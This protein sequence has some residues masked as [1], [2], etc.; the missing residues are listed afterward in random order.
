VREELERSPAFART[1]DAYAAAREHGRCNTDGPEA[2]LADFLAERHFDTLEAA[3]VF[4]QRLAV[5]EA[6][7][8]T[9]RAA[10]DAEKPTAGRPPQ[11]PQESDCAPPSAA[12]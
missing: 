6:E 8:R 3:R 5:R 11:R 4:V 9:R 2:L 12:T 7:R 10:E 1:E